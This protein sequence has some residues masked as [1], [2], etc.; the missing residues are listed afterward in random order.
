MQ[1]TGSWTRA[2]DAPARSW[3]LLGIACSVAGAV[4]LLALAAAL[5]P[6]VPGT[7]TGAVAALPVTSATAAP[8]GVPVPRSGPLSAADTT[9]PSAASVF[10]LDGSTDAPAEAAPT[11]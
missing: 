11:F 3:S 9:V 10:G 2:D 1:A 4:G 6:S 7:D 8:A 5:L